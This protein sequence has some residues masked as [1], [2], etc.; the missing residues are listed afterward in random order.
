MIDERRAGAHPAYPVVLVLLAV[1]TALAPFDPGPPDRLG[2]FLTMSGAVY[3]YAA[4]FPILRRFRLAGAAALLIAAHAAF[5]V[6][7]GEPQHQ[8]VFRFLNLGVDALVRGQD[9]YLVSAANG[10]PFKFTYPPGVLLLVA[11]FRLLV[12]DIRW[13][14][15]VAEALCVAL[16]PQVWRR[17]AGGPRLSR[18]QEALVLIPLVLPRTSQAFFVF[19]NHEWLLL[20]LALAVIVLALDR[21]WLAA[22]VVA[23]IGIASKQYF[24]VFPLLFL[25]PVVR[26]RSLAVA[27]GMAIAITLPFVAWDPSDFFANVF[28]NL[29]SAPDPDR[30]TLWA[31]AANLGIDLGRTGAA[32]LGAAGAVITAVLAWRS[33][34]TLGAR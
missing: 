23:G 32:S 11:P 10:G 28:G 3:F 31:L 22:G 15:I 25:L 14:Y 33:R 29:S 17:L 34:R 4:S 16:I 20:A 26:R 1:L 24:I 18:W 19:S 5:I 8:D 9:P 13:S 6:H 12:G 7:I 30:L 27:L 2:Q 21:R